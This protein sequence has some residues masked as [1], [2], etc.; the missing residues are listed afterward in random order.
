MGPVVG[1]L[2][3][4][5]YGE[6]HERTVQPLGSHTF[7]AGLPKVGRMSWCGTEVRPLLRVS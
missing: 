7:L 6:L 2:S 3:I 1:P 4:T 5:S